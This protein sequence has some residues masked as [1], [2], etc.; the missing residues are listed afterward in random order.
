[1]GIHTYTRNYYREN[2][3]TSGTGV[4]LEPSR[5]SA[6]TST[7]LLVPVT[8]AERLESGTRPEPAPPLN[9][10][11][12]LF[13]CTG[14]ESWVADQ[15]TVFAR[16]VQ[17]NDTAYRRLDPEYYAW[18]RS[19]MQLAKMAADAGQLGREPF[20]ELRR[21]FNAMHEWAVERFGESGLAAAVRD[22]DARE[23]RPPVAE[24]EPQV[25]TP[26]P[27]SDGRAGIVV[28]AAAVAKVDAI[29][30]CALTLGWSQESL[31]QTRGRLRFPFGN[32]YGLVCFIS[33]ADRIGQVAADAIEIIGPPPRET[34]RRFYRCPGGA[35]RK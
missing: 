21:R 7:G 19:K 35:S 31:Y 22:L 10:N 20:D 25:P 11:S 14:L 9:Q 3:E 28:S 5:V 1:M 24:E 18:L 32:E 29:R 8:A 23:Y 2:R 27:A 13:V 33:V 4:P 15:P 26:V 16:D 34:C 17:I 12:A 30:D 6:S